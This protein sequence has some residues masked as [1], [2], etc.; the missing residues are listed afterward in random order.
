MSSGYTRVPS[1][2]QALRNRAVERFKKAMTELREEN[3]TKKRTVVDDL[4]A[5]KESHFDTA[6]AMQ[7]HAMRQFPE[8]SRCPKRWPS[9]WKRTSAR[10]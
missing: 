5:N 6:I 7:R 3:F 10:R 8:P 9:F 1:E 2:A 4:P